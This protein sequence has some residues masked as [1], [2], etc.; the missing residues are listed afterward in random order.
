MIQFQSFNDW[1][2]EDLMAVDYQTLLDRRA[3][4]AEEITQTIGR[5]G[6]LCRQEVE[7][8]DQLRRAAER[9]G[10]RANAFSTTPTVMDAIN[11]ELTHAGLTLRR[12]DPRMRLNTVVET[13]NR[14]YRG[15]MTGREPVSSPSA[16]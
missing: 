5:L 3:E 7:L 13:Q 9:A 8:Q 14:R 10:S 4:I 6:V 2:V 12:A 16:A 11:S 1:T 15:Q